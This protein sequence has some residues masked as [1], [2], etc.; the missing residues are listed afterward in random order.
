MEPEI[1]RKVEW[2]EGVPRPSARG[3]AKLEFT[4]AG[5]G[6]LA[7]FFSARDVNLF[8]RRINPLYRKLVSESKQM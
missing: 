2:G 3:Q 4:D 8:P 5:E 6:K 7:P 1:N